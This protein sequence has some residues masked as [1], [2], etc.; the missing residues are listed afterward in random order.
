MFLCIF[1]GRKEE[2]QISILLVYFKY[3]WVGTYPQPPS[4]ITLLI[5]CMESANLL[6][7]GFKSSGMVNC[8]KWIVGGLCLHWETRSAYYKDRG[9]IEYKNFTGLGKL[10][11]LQSPIPT[12]KILVFALID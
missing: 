8:K 7:S 1:F 9:K 10:H 4:K 3:K 11:H 6:L 2:V 5:L 12:L